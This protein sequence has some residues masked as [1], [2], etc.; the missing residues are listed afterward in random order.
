M[1]KIVY[2][3][4]LECQVYKSKIFVEGYIVLE[5]HTCSKINLSLDVV[6]KRSDGYHLLETV[7]YPVAVFD[8]LS[9][10]RRD[11]GIHIFSNSD[12]LPCD[13]SNLVFKAAKSLFEYAGI[14]YGVEIFINKSIPIGAGLGGGSSNA[15]CVL[16]SLNKMFSLELSYA[17]LYSL[18][19]DLGSDVPFFLKNEPVLAT[20]VG[21][22]FSSVAALPECYIL[23]LFPGFSV[24]TRKIYYMIDDYRIDETDRP[25]T[26]GVVCALQNGSIDD[27][28][29]YAKNVL[30][31]VTFDLY[32]IL[33]EYKL[34]LLQ[35]GAKVC[36][37]SGSGS[38]IFALFNK[39]ICK[40]DF[41]GHFPIKEDDNMEI[42]IFK[43]C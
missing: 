32:P 28:S 34:R 10:T 25:D 35:L 14:D 7:M 21:D 9:F 23:V 6:G 22:I 36:L 3:R 20:G 13:E 42:F 39:E 2:C 11:R 24:S 31:L 29:L 38:S 18:A 12:V 27:L 26:E 8:S 1:F 43:N 40:D 4:V 17:E 19:A 16:K 30:E 41:I 37:M 15:A 33:K 5:C